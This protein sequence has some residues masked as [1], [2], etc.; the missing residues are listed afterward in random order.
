M[1]VALIE[2]VKR[3]TQDPSF[4]DRFQELFLEKDPDIARRFSGMDRARMKFSLSRSVLL[5]VKH[6]ARMPGADAELERLA[7]RLGPAGLG[8]PA[9][10]FPLWM[11]ALLRAVKEVDRA[12]TPELER[13]WRE[14]MTREV[15]ALV[16]RMYYRSDVR[17]GP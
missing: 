12:L 7:T 14:V 17:G 1:S 15:D 2:S 6:A 5:L 3:C 4:L 8:I 10:H 9:G 13:E 16:N 11:E